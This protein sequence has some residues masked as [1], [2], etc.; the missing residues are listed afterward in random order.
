M[1]LITRTKKQSNERYS[2]KYIQKILY[3]LFIFLSCK[4]LHSQESSFAAVVQFPHGHIQWKVNTRGGLESPLSFK[5]FIYNGDQIEI[6]KSSYIKFITRGQCIVTAHGFG[7]LWGGG[8]LAAPTKPHA[9]WVF[10]N[11]ATRWICPE[12]QSQYVQLD[13][14]QI[15]IQDGEF[16]YYNGELFVIKGHVFDKNEK[17]LIPHR[18]YTSHE[19]SWNVHR[20]TFERNELWHFNKSFPVPK[21]STQLK[22][23][24]LN[25]KWRL[26]ITPTFSIYGKQD[27]QNPYVEMSKFQS[28]GVMLTI[29][30]LWKKKRSILFSISSSEGKDINADSSTQNSQPS[31]VNNRLSDLLFE[32]GYRQLHLRNW[33]YYTKMGM[34]QSKYEVSTFFPYSGNQIHRTEKYQIISFHLGVDRLFLTDWLEHYGFYTFAEIQYTRTVN[35]QSLRSNDEHISNPSAVEMEKLDGNYWT[36][37]GILGLGFTI[38]F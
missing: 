5:S 7:F 20:S 18:S 3:I 29:N 34:G 31:S 4:E 9:P 35:H 17:R 11:L 28:S 23:P 32:I 27:H 30:Y 2:F 38:Q 6:S 22:K 21:E 14:Q 19:A 25:P 33:S 24:F 10:S 16:F 36:L 12:S 26:M 1:S 37:S 15:R 13:N 8:T